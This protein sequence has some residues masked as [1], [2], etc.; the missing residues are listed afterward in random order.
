MKRSTSLAGLAL[1]LALGVLN[2]AGC[3]GSSTKP[4]T[5]ADTWPNSDLVVSGSWLADHL[6][7]ANQVIVDVRADTTYARGHVPNAVSLPIT[8]GGGLFDLGS[9]GTTGTDLKPA[10]EIAA[11]LG[12]A[13]IT[14]STTIIVCGADTDWLAGRMFW[15]LE[16]LGATDVRMLD[17][18]YAKWVA[19]GRT[20]ATAAPTTHAATFTPS[21][22]V[23]TLATKE[24]V[25]AHYADT[26][27]H[28]VVDSRNAADFTAKHIPHALNIL[29]GDFLNG[30]L[31]VKGRAD[32]QTFLDG[33]AITTGKNVIAHC[34][35]G[36]R[37]GMHYFVFRLMGYTVSNYDGSWVEWNAD[38]NTPKEP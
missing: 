17:G 21:V 8:P 36:Y 14:R 9:S 34:Y 4:T 25:L 29:M 7:T 10:A 13:G 2:A 30:D 28:A 35:V 18:G 33:K 12:N 26:V 20:T 19:D 22:N 11:V 15:M 16:Y 37:S 1:I 38:P 32:L 3:G 5:P 27:N 24:T 6:T 23:S 31:T